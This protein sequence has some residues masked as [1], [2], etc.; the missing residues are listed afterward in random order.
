MVTQFDLVNQVVSDQ[1]I[2]KSHSTA[3]T[4]IDYVVY[5]TYVLYNDIS[6]C[7]KN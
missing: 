2:L 4:A 3:S 7:L 6:I 5:K 1:I